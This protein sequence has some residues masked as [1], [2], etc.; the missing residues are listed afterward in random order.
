MANIHSIV[1]MRQKRAGLV[2]QMEEVLD[3]AR[4]EQRALSADENVQVDKII[5]DEVELRKQI[6][7][8]EWLEE[9]NAELSGHEN[10]DKAAD[11]ERREKTDYQQAFKRW[12]Q[13]GT[14]ELTP[15]E[16]SIMMEKRA[17]STTGGS[18]SQGGYTI[19]QGFYDE[20]TKAMKWFGGMRN[21][22]KIITTESGNVL[23]IPSA[24]DTTN[25]GAI[26]AESTAA[27]SNVDP[28][29]GSVN[30]GAYKYTSNIVL[31]PIE[32]LQ[33]S[34][35]NLESYLAEILGERIARINN[36]HFTVG[37]GTAQPRG[38]VI[39]ATLGKTGTTGQTTSIIYDDLVDLEHSVD[40]AYRRKASWM[41]HDTSLAAV[42]KIKASTGEPLFVPG[43]AYGEPDRILGYTYE[44]N[45]DV[46]TM[47][48]NAKSLLFG[49]FS[50]YF[51]RDVMDMAL[52][53]FGEKYMDA[54]Q[55]GFVVFS[56][57]DGR[58]VNA[59]TNPIKY[60]AN[61]GT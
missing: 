35:F 31:V 5:A 10:R 37:T 46:A 30:L 38:V 27:A 61:S 36:T 13:V 24:N 22:A 58:L 1:E 48:A 59:G 2:K 20:L 50:N 45:N 39:D 14:N 47:A 49:D 57:A 12:L 51:I 52:V 28:V 54:A 26:L 7:R 8:E 9:R 40:K 29:F 41:L 53:R 60:Y 42:K 11:K 19:P 25:V 44:V 34:A 17:L 56:R 32:L 16:R 3:R 55:V 4:N 43:I 33:D 23:P 21:V 6:E 18:G 15:E